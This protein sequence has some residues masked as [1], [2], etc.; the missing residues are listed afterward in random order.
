MPHQDVNGVTIKYQLDGPEGSPVLTFAHGNAFSLEVWSEQVAA[1][2]DRYR[3]LCFDLRGH[4]GSSLGNTVSLR[5]EDMAG[6]HAALKAT[7]K[8]KK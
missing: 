7:L 2:R 3:T 4:G 1:F 5:M 8:N 6:Y